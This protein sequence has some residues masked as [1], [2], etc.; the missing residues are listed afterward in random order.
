MQN[1]NERVRSPVRR[2]PPTLASFDFTWHPR[3]SAW[4]ILLFFIL[5]LFFF[6]SFIFTLSSSFFYHRV[7]DIISRPV[8]RTGRRKMRREKTRATHSIRLTPRSVFFLSLP[9][10]HFLFVF[11]TPWLIQRGTPAPPPFTSAATLRSHP[12]VRPHSRP[13]RRRRLAVDYVVKGQTIIPTLR[14]RLAE[15]RALSYA[16]EIDNDGNGVNT[17][18]RARSLLN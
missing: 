1:G 13:R 14:R 9:V 12:P 10:R 5:L 18:D 17:S 16:R 6:C 11:R 15:H 4:A 8:T 3:Y 7:R 2:S